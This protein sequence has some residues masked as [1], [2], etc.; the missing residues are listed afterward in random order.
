[1]ININQQTN[2]T[3]VLYLNEDVSITNPYYIF[4]FVDIYNE[5]IVVSLEDETPDEAY[6]QFSFWDASITTG[7]SANGELNIYESTT[8]TSIVDDLTLI[9]NGL[10]KFLETKLD[11]IIFDPSINYT[12]YVFDP[13][14]GYNLI[15]QDIVFD[16]IWESGQ[17]PLLG[18]PAS[19]IIQNSTYRFVSDSSITY[20]NERVG[21]VT[22]S[23]VD[24]SII[25][26]ITAV[27]SSLVTYIDGKII[28]VDASINDL[29]VHLEFVNYTDVVNGGEDWT[30]VNIDEVDG[31]SS[32]ATQNTTELIGGNFWDK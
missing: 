12:D 27:D 31:G 15:D 9:Y 13:C 24:G 30:I 18:I 20:W 11:D 8:D 19:Q 3:L 1:M 5:K 25:T 29:Y 22:F 28:E 16:P 23:Y 7:L 17:L 6:N 10:Y 4:E 26:A 21:E 14:S 32:W 2:N